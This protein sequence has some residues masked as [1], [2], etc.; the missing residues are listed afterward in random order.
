MTQVFGLW[1][2]DVM[3]VALGTGA[4][5]LPT[6]ARSEGG[7]P[8][9]TAERNALPTSNGGSSAALLSGRLVLRPL[10]AARAL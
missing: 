1:P 9:D 4:G 6:A 5:A 2:D 3:V 10:R 7:S 8:H